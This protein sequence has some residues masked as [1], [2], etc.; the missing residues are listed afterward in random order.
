MIINLLLLLPLLSVAQEAVVSFLG[1][2]IPVNATLNGSLQGMAIH[3]DQCILLRHGGQCVT[4][5]L[6]RQLCTGIQQLADNSTHC[7]NASLSPFHRNGEP[8]PLLYVSSCFG[9][10]ACYVYRITQNDNVL[11][12]RIFFDSPAFPIAQ[13]WCIDIE[14]RQLYAF[15]GKRGGTMYLKRFALPEPS[16]R[17]VHLTDADVLQTIPINCVKVAQGSKVS[18]GIAYLPDGDTA[19]G[20]FLHIIDLATGKETRTIDLNPIGLEPEGID[21]SGE[22]IYISFNTPNPAHNCIYRF[23]K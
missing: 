23:S 3:C 19:G 10:K 7:N 4:L 16:D 12:Q 1:D 13:D 11:L 20:Y 15:G 9:D 14:R 22:W 17:D 5:D 2:L 8:F 21:I 6:Q 18:D